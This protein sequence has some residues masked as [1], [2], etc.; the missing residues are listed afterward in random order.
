M[1]VRC[2][3]APAL[4]TPLALVTYCFVFVKKCEEVWQYFLSRD[5]VGG[6][7]KTAKVEI[8]WCN[9]YIHDVPIYTYVAHIQGKLYLNA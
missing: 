6:E 1:Y 8:Y 2:I 4:V 5:G 9:V 7:K 3:L